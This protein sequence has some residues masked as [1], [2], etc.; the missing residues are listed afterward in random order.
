MKGKG[1]TMVIESVKEKAV[2]KI[3]AKANLSG[4]ASAVGSAVRDALV[5]FCRQSEEFSEAVC[6]TGKCIE[7]C[8][9]EITKDIGSSI[10]DFEL[11]RRAVAFWMEGA[12]V[13]AELRIV[14]PESKTPDVRETGR[15]GRKVKILS[16]EELL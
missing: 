8:L 9:N 2:E 3:T 1:E 7:E 10:S 15:R 12:D 14:L 4:K 16:L 13:F 11:Y 6:A 5:Q